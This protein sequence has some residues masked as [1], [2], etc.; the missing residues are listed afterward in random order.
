MTCIVGIE[1][2]GRVLIGADSAGT[3]G[4]LRQRVRSDE[5]VFTADGFAFG[6][7]TSFRM[8][9]LLRYRL[10]P[11]PFIEGMGLDEYM[12]TH[13]VDQVRAV[14]KQGGY[15]VVENGTERGGTF[16]VGVRGRLY[17]VEG[18]YQV[19]HTPHGYEA[20]GCGDDLAIGSLFTTAKNP[21]MSARVR[22]RTALE[23]AAMFSAG[24]APPFNFVEA[25]ASV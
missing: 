20:V 25:R 8:G 5:K 4:G 13:F 9:Q 1:D 7:T 2:K 18:D 19:A 14:F 10:T 12:A 15:A 22:C 23:A 6:F 16:L 21:K 11:P 3:A 24:V 17:S